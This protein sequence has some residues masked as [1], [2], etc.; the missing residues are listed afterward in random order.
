MVYRQ[1]HKDLK[2][3]KRACREPHYSDTN[4]VVPQLVFWINHS[5]FDLDIFEKKMHKL[6]LSLG[7]IRQWRKV[8]RQ[9]LGYSFG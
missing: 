2:S 6:V 4:V 8:G 9:C 1:A 3:V 7:N 5:N